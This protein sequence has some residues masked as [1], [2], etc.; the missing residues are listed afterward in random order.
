MPVAVKPEVKCWS[1]QRGLLFEKK[2]SELVLSFEKEM[3][4]SRNGNG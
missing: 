4:V 2:L 1:R 3:E